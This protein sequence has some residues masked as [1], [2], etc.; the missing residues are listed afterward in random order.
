[1]RRDSKIFVA[2]NEIILKVIYFDKGITKL[3][4]GTH[5]DEW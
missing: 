5:P 4:L 1:M 3:V 2:F